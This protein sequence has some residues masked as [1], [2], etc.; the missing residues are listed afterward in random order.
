MAVVI[1]DFEAVQDAGADGGEAGAAPPP[2]P[3]AHAALDR[4]L[5]AR[6]VRLARLW[7]S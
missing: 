3:V 4:L 1:Q 5:A 7:A 2:A 6:R